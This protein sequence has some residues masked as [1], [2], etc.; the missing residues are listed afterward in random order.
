M[1]TSTSQQPAAPHTLSA[2]HASAPSTAEPASSALEVPRGDVT[3]PLN[4]YTPPADGAV[5]FMYVE[6]PPAG[7]PKDNYFRETKQV[8]VHDIRGEEAK[9]TF[10][11]D[12]FAILQGIES[13][14]KEFTNDA[15]IKATYYP[16]VESLLLSHIPGAN[17]VVI[18]DHTIRRSSPNAHREPVFR[19][20]I[21]Q[22]ASAARERV[23]R[24]VPDPAE[25]EKL[26]QGR[27]RI[28]NVWRPLN[29][30]VLSNPLAFASSHTV[31][32][33]DVVPVEHRYPDRTGHTAS[34]VWNEGQKWNYLSGMENNERVLLEC[35]D[36]AGEEGPLAGESGVQGGRVPHSA[37]TD[38][39]TPEGARGRESI[40][41]RCLV[42]GP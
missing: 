10:D 33:E 12:A 11:K 5:P 38:P 37:F 13:Q 23:R 16:E 8:L 18:F 20:H 26:L 28:I 9:Y 25:A 35:Y 42:F 36:S 24:H 1:A 22:T 41:V 3:A 2:I 40:E 29:G 30:P 31:R 32:D 4:F 6:A 7:E 27:F 17:R 39:R 14:E 19:T 34:I 15:S 21:D